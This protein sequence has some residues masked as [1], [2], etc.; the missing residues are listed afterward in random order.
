M[1]I[2]NR[3]HILFFTWRDLID[4][5]DFGGNEVYIDKVANGLV[6]SGHKVTVFSSKAKS[7]K[8]KETKNGVSYIRKGSRFSVYFWAFVHYF[9]NLKNKVDFVIDTENGIPFFTPLY[10]K[11]PKL[12][13]VHHFHNGQWFKEFAFPI[14]LFGYCIEKFVMPFIYKKTK[15]VTVSDSSR[16]DLEDMGFNPENIKIAHNGVN[17]TRRSL[18]DKALYDRPTVLYLGR[19]RKY[20]RV[21]LAIKAIKDLKKAIPDVNLIIAGQGDDVDR[22]KAL[23]KELNVENNV[24]FLG[25][26]DD[27]KRDELFKKSWVYVNPSSKEGWGIV[28]IEANYFGTPVVGF[29]V[30]GVRDSIKDGYSGYLAKSYSG[31]VNSLRS[32]LIDEASVKCFEENC[33]KWSKNFKWEKTVKVFE[34]E[35]EKDLIKKNVMRPIFAKITKDIFSE[36][37]A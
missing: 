25:F 28:N 24:E 16:L 7:Q 23:T 8:N 9:T 20:K 6:K 4:N 3:K 15:I 11:K 35:I 17:I 26:V 22:L 37:L 30:Y 27:T 1:K 5:K 12:M 33:K 10:V 18:N 21:D 2:K 13:L 14:A 32:L 19:I 31:F 36:V 29:D 34:N